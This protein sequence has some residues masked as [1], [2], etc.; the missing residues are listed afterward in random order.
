[1]LTLGRGLFFGLGAYGVAKTDLLDELGEHRDVG[2]L[3]REVRR[4]A[5]RADEPAPARGPVQE[6]LRAAV[7]TLGLVYAKACQT[8]GQYCVEMWDE[9]APSFTSSAIPSRSAPP[10]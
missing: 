2:R 4:I 9:W 1:M 5:E 10:G 6:E 3:T 8:T 7:D